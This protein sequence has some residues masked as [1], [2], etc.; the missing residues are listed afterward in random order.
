MKEF[1]N[2]FCKNREL[3]IIVIDPVVDQAWKYFQIDYPNLIQT[4]PLLIQ[5]GMENLTVLEEELEKLSLGKT[6]AVFCSD[7]DVNNLR[8]A[9]A[10]HRIY[11]KADETRYILRTNTRNNFPDSVLQKFLG[12]NHILIPTYDWIK[13][14][15]EDYF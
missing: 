14:Y 2:D 4:P 13:A 9:T 5:S 8:Y 10:F 11:D 15:F 12:E 3:R 7:S 1:K 6:I